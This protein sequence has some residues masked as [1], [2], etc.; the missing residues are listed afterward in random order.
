MLSFI[1][2]YCNTFLFV[3]RP[4]EDLPEVVTRDQLSIIERLTNSTQS[5][6]DTLFRKWGNLCASNPW[7]VILLGLMVASVLCVG[8]LYLDMTTDPVELWASPTSK[9]RI[10]KNYYDENFEPFYRTAQV[11]IR[12][13]GYE[14]FEYNNLTFG[15]VFNKT[16]L[17]D[18]LKLQNYLEH[19]MNAS[20]DGKP[21][22]L[23]DV[24]NKPLA[25]DNVNCNIQSILNYWKN[26]ESKLN[27]S[28]VP[29]HSQMCIG[30]RYSDECLGTYGG[31]VLPHVALGGFLSADQALSEE[32]DY[33]IADTLVITFPINNY[34]DG[35]KLAPALAWEKVFNEYLLNYKHPSMDIAF[36]SER[37]I[38][39]EL[40]RMSKSDVPTIIISYVIMFI[41]IALALGRTDQ[42][43]KV[44]MSTRVTL[45]L[46]GVLIVLLSVFAAVGLYGFAGV[47]CTMLIIEVIPFLVLA[48]GVDNI[49]ILFEAYA[50]LDK[51]LL[52]KYY[53][54]F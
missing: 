8:I 7:K 53:F 23:S 18:V 12:P 2:Q 45:G 52:A 17:R 30:N 37:S 28:D 14:A 31:P 1:Q 34:F 20:I 11:F 38:E 10:Q 51:G 47:P 27:E 16:F 15:P 4:A 22:R 21:V 33:L 24:C 54:I 49:F 3:G 50:S 35:S 43:S 32:P 48:V 25:P 9:S 36:R 44:L 6:V 42:P 46:G 19:E 39:D 5:T 13:V 29:M 41:Y 26:D 40:E